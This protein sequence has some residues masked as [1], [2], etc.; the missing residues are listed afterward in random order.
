[1]YKFIICLGNVTM[2]GVRFSISW[3][4]RRGK[5]TLHTFRIRVLVKLRTMLNYGLRIVRAGNGCFLFV[6]FF[7]TKLATFFFILLL[8][9]RFVM[10]LDAFQATTNPS[11]SKFVFFVEFV[12]TRFA[13]FLCLRTKHASKASMRERKHAEHE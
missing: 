1:M 11:R 7:P 3:Q 10:L 2:N 6:C 13:D 12:S 8:Q 4:F 9:A 5:R